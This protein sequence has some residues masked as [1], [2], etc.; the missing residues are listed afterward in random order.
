[1]AFSLATVA[2]YFPAQEIHFQRYQPRVAAN[3]IINNDPRLP[4]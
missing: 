2:I 4:T 1:V 3:T